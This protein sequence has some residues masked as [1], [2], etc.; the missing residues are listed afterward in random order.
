MSQQSTITRQDIAG[1]DT[2]LS[3]VS[4]PPEERFFQTLVE[5]FIKWL[6]AHSTSIAA[7]LI[8][9]DQALL[10][11]YSESPEL[12]PGIPASVSVQPTEVFTALLTLEDGVAVA[13]ESL[14]EVIQH[15]PHFKNG[16]TEAFQFVRHHLKA[17]QTF[18]LL[19]FGQNRMLVHDKGVGI[20]DWINDPRVVE[21]KQLDASV[22]TPAQIEKELD[23]FHKVQLES[24]R[25]TMAR[26]MWQ[27]FEEPKKS[28]LGPE[29]E[30]HVQSAMLTHFRGVYRGKN[31]LVDEEVALNEGRVDLRIARFD[32]ASKEVITMIELKVLTP[33]KS[34]VANLAWAHKGIEQAYGYKKTINTDAAFACIYDA[35]RT[36]VDTM[37]T[38]Q[39]DA[40]AKDVILKLHA[41]EVPEPRRRKKDKDDS[42]AV[43]KPV[44]LPRATPLAKKF[45]GNPAAKKRATAKTS[46]KPT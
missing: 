26:L 5:Y 19:L 27:I 37:P 24:Y 36:K 21:I 22:I 28:V 6:V 39:P 34:D 43:T 8:K 32:S 40:E 14:S 11:L 42:A 18:A 33:E 2:G 1:L 13:G 17:D 45:K 46:P 3:L 7:G 25:G 23:A 41:M 15:V 44:K 20:E 31:A 35:R 29:P 10:M 16:A 4:G 12:E 9:R 30:L 38:L